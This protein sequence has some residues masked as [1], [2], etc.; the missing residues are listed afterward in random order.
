MNIIILPRKN[1]SAY[2]LQLNRWYHYTLTVSL[3]SLLMALPLS[4]GYY[5][6]GNSEP[7]TTVSEWRQAL[8]ARSQQ[9]VVSSELSKAHIEALVQRLGVLQ[10][11]VNRLDAFG[12]RLVKL[13]NLDDGEFDFESSPGV[14]GPDQSPGLMLNV[15][16]DISDVLGELALRLEKQ[17]SQFRVLDRLILSRNLDKEVFP[18]GW[19]IKKGWISSAFGKRKNPFNGKSEYH[20]G[21]DFAGKAGSDVV[22]VA[23]GVVIWAGKRSGYGKLVEIDHGNRFSTRYGHNKK[24]NVNVGDV[25][26][27]GQVIAKMGSTGRST[28]PHVHLEVL[29]RGKQINP[30]KFISSSR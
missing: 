3:L 17:E 11:H 10:A 29:E 18:A 15:R 13:A 1:S 7:R 20:K 22:A 8:I 25:V 9:A 12:S 26:K 21:I 24:L 5:L 14:G 4:L 16:H 19:P 2:R 6:G 27:K 23:S 28:G 30:Y